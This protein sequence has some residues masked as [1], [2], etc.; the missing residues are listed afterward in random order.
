M[1]SPRKLDVLDLILLELDPLVFEEDVE[2]F[3]GVEQMRTNGVTV[4]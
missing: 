4:T 3:A 2:L 1:R